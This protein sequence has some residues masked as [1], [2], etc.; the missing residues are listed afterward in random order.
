VQAG[1]RFTARAG[2]RA[3]LFSQALAG[4]AHANA[5]GRGFPSY[6]E[7]VA[8]TAGA[9]LDCRLSER[10]SLRLVQA[11]YLQTRLGGGVQHNFRAGAGVVFHFGGR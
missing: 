3:S 5:G 4:F 1:A 11:E 7:S 9:G 8:W 6:H 2:R 10:I